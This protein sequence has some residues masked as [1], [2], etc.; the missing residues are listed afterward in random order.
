VRIYPA[1]LQTKPVEMARMTIR[2]T[3]KKDG[4]HVLACQRAD[5]SA[6]WQRGPG[7]FFPHHDLGHYAIETT[8]N[9]RLAFFGLLASGWEITDFGAPWPRGP[10]PPES[11]QDAALAEYLA[12]ALDLE[13]HTGHPMSV[14]E[15]H[16]M[17]D[18]HL[19]ELGATLERRVTEEELARIRAA[20]AQLTAR[21]RAL[22]PGDSMELPFPAEPSR[23]V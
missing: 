20:V 4:T 14:D 15:F 1:F 17:V 5:G 7:E 10:M 13:R 11:I 2:F 9:L 21:W 6:T 18:Q 12:G 23:Q 22:P 8:L 3:K 19:G 16:A